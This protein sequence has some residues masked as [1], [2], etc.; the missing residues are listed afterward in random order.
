MVI[1][2]SKPASHVLDAMAEQKILGGLELAR[3]FPGMTDGILVNVTETKTDAD[4][5]SFISSLKQA[6]A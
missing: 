4:L 1:K 2:L 6:L 5:D 3:C